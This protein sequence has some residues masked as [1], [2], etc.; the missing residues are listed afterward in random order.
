M[1]S[2]CTILLDISIPG[3]R[4]LKEKRSVIKPIIHRLRR[5]F[6]V[7]VAEIDFQDKW[8]RSA[9]LCA[10]V[11]NDKSFS[12]SQMM[13]VVNYVENNFRNINLL[14]HKIMFL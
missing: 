11:S 8:S 2:I 13:K 5:E 3:T 14:D 12:Q 6:N 9:I 10:H 1:A 7:S 4:S